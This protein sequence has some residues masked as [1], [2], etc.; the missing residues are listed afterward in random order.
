MNFSFF[1]LK[2]NVTK[3]RSQQLLSNFF[4]LSIASFLFLH[5]QKKRHRNFSNIFFLEKKDCFA[6]CLLFYYIENAKLSSSLV[7]KM[8]KRFVILGTKDALVLFLSN[9]QLEFSCSMVS[10]FSFW[11][12]RSFPFSFLVFSP[13]F[14]LPKSPFQNSKESSLKEQAILGSSFLPRLGCGSS[15]T[16]INISYALFEMSHPN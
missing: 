13:I 9:F 6:Q 11:F 7:V 8:F 10:F 3:N 1:N 4:P 15:G 5:S 2:G 16:S 14:F 12:K